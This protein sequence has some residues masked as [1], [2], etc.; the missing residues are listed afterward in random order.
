MLYFFNMSSK[1]DGAAW[2]NGVCNRAE[3][4]GVEDV[5]SF[6]VSSTTDDDDDECS[7]VSCLS[8]FTSINF[9][10]IAFVGLDKTGAGRGRKF[11]CRKTSLIF[12]C[13]H[14]R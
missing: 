2:A 8:F 13:L 3:T 14:P 4:F 1:D 10:C 12:P 9:F 6:N 11:F 5:V 7:E